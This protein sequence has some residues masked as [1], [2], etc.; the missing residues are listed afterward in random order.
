M[1]EDQIIQFDILKPDPLDKSSQRKAGPYMSRLLDD[2]E[3][4]EAIEHILTT[5]ENWSDATNIYVSQVD[6]KLIHSIGKYRNKLL[7]MQWQFTPQS[8]PK[9]HAPSTAANTNIAA[10]AIRGPFV[11]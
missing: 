7:A 8:I 11:T 6:I 1:N 10:K 9:P 5:W 4:T 3:D 2:L